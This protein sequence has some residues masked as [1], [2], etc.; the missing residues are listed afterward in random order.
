M[1]ALEQYNSDMEGCEEHDPVERLRFFLSLALVGQD[2]I[3][4][5]QFI[6]GVSQQLAAKDAQITELK[7][8]NSELVKHHDSLA[9][10]CDELREQLAERE[11]ERRGVIAESKMLHPLWLE[12]PKEE[13]LDTLRF[14]A[15]ITAALLEETDSYQKQNVLLREALLVHAHQIENNNGRSFRTCCDVPHSK[16]H[17]PDCLTGKALD[18]TADLAGLVVCDAVPVMK[19]IRNEAGQIMAQSGDG[20]Y[21]DIS[22]HVG[23]SFYLAKEKS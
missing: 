15:A 21:F 18:A 12:R 4:V 3:D 6:D 8:W 11:Q 20:G 19:V 2:W 9:D 5:E 7:A 10:K 14:Q 17:H 13:L 1:T 22:T 16:P 23:K